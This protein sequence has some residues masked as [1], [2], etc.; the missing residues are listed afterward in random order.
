M[1][2]SIRSRDFCFAVL[3]VVVDPP[4]DDDVELDELLP[5]DDAT[6]VTADMADVM[7]ADATADAVCEA[8]E[9]PPPL[10]EEEDMTRSSRVVDS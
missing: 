4:C 5:C 3:P 2:L 7:T 10:P 1:L 8:R 6:L 9:P